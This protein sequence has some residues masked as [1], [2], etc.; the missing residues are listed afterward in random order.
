[1]SRT[2]EIITE[3][4]FLALGTPTRMIMSPIFKIDTR[5]NISIDHRKSTPLRF[6]FFVGLIPLIFQHVLKLP[7][8]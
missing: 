2:S 5:D 1:M 7:G 6:A 4:Q 8:A 3:C